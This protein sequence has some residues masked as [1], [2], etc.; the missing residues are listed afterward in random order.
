MIRAL[1]FDLD[2]TLI[3]YDAAYETALTASHTI[4]AKRH[5][6]VSRGDLQRA[7]HRA[8]EKRYGYANTAGFA[9]AGA[10]TVRAMREALTAD[11]LAFLETGDHADAAF[12]GQLIAAHEAVEAREIVAFPD[13]HTTL[14]ALEERFKLGV[15]TNG[16]RA[17]Q[18]AKLAANGLASRFATTIV[19]SEFG[20][21]KPDRRIF[22]HA[23]KIAGL[24]P[25][26]LL[27]V[28]NSPEADVAGAIGAGWT[29]VW[30]NAHG[31][32]LPPGIPPPHYEIR[33]LTEML[34]LPP[35][36]DALR[37]D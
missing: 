6:H 3:R 24:A 2:D 23:A 13:T 7:I 19:D 29:S 25:D 8:Y 28:G 20:H 21:P 31:A 17:M 14:D 35:I 4:L 22:D 18:R 33:T 15:I 9:E 37:R 30:V 12:V 27:F 5:P 11:A 32:P 34:H 10:I 1:F 16:P 26:E 36:A